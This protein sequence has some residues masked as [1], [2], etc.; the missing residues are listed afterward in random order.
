MLALA[1][2][3]YFLHPIFLLLH[4]VF[5]LDLRLGQIPPNIGIV[6]SLIIS[7]TV[8][9]REFIRLCIREESA[10]SHS[11]AWFLFGLPVSSLAWIWSSAAA[12]LSG[13]V[14]VKIHSVIAYGLVI[15]VVGIAG[16]VCSMFSGGYS[17]E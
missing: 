2:L 13:A 17:S 5:G 4:F 12:I 3:A 7:I 6:L 9:I 16:I 10:S 1:L 11:S 14:L 15:T 8:W